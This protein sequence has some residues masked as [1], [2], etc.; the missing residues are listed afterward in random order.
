V[1]P[2]SF[3]LGP[4]ALNLAREQNNLGHNAD[5]WCV[6][7]E[8]DRRWATESSGLEPDNIRRFGTIGPRKLYFSLEMLRASTQEAASISIVHQHALWTGLSL[9]T[10]RLRERKGIPAVIA[11]HGMLEKW[12]LMKSRWKKGFFLALCERD[13]LFAASCLH[14]C[15]NQELAGFREFGLTNPVAVIPNGISNAWLA[16]AGNGDAFRDRFKLPRDKRIMLFLSRISPV[17]GLLMLMDALDAVR[18][19][20]GDWLVVVAGDDEFNHKEEVLEKVKKLHL[21]K[22]VLFTG[23]VVDQVKRDAYAAAELFVLP[24]KRENYGIVVAEA[25]GVGVPV[26]T[27]KGAPWEQLVN[28]NCGWWTEVDTE[29]FA[30]SLMVALNSSPDELKQMGNRGKELISTCY[31]W[32]KSAMMT[33]ELYKW[34]LGQADRPDFVTVD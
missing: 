2:R 24:T 29:S 13:T 15:S 6:D 21:E 9:I 32:S 16:S 3:G 4:V 8:N 33:I 18:C 7:N 20:L 12:A 17:K 30:Y 19:H 10:N 11:P 22:C 5:V 34:L 23:L 25:L 28:Q 1:G 14:A 31:T 27:T 26:L